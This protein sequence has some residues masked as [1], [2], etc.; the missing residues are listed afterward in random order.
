MR[1]HNTVEIYDRS[2]GNIYIYRER[3]ER[4]QGNI[5]MIDLKAVCIYMERDNKELEIHEISQGSRE[6]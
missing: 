3:D 5:E 2:Q 6:R 4:S 1:D